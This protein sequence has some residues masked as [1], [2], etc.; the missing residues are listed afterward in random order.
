MVFALLCVNVLSAQDLWDRY[1]V[2]SSFHDG[3][4]TE[5]NPYQ[6]RTGAEL[7]YFVN[8]VN[9]GNDFKGKT[10]KL[11]NDI[12]LNNDNF[13]ISKPFAGSFDGGGH[14]LT[15][16][17]GVSSDNQPFTDVSGR[18]HHLGFVISMKNQY[19]GVYYGY[20]SVVG[21]LKESGILEDIHYTVNYSADIFYYQPALAY[22]N[23]G[24]IRN[25]YAGGSFHTYGGYSNTDGS[26]LVRDNYETGVIENCYAYVNR[27]I[28][29]V[30]YQA[31]PLA[32]TDKGTIIHNSRNIDELNKWVDEHPGHSSW[33]DT[34]TY[35]LVDFNPS[36]ECSI[37]FVDTLFSTFTPT[38][39]VGRGQ[40]IG[41]LPTPDADCTLAGWL[42]AG[43]LVKESDVVNA[44]WALFAKWEQRIKRQPTIK[45][46]SVG[47]DDIAHAT[48]QWFANSGETQY[49]ADV[50]LKCSSDDYY[51][52][53]I[54]ILAKAG[55]TLHFDYV[56]SSEKDYDIF[57]ASIDGQALVMASGERHGNITYV[58]PTDGTYKLIL[59]YSKDE[60]TSEGL[61]MANVT[62][63][64][65]CDVDDK[66]ECTDN[67]LPVSLVEKESNYFCK[68]CY[69]NTGIVLYTDTIHCVPGEVPEYV[70]Y[71][72]YGADLQ[73]WVGT[74]I[75]LSIEL[76]NEAEVKLCQFDLRLPDGVTVATKSNGKLD[77]K[78]TE[79]AENHS[80]SSQKLSNGDYRFVISSL[81]NDS[82]TG[83]N[84]TLMEITLNVLET[85]EAGEYTVKVLNTELSVPNGN[86]LM[87]VNPADTESKLT[88]HDYTPGD[89]NNDKSVSVT[90]V[91]CAI[92]YILEQIPSVFIFKAADMNSDNNVSVTDVGMIINVILS[93]G[94]ARSRGNDMNYFERK[95]NNE[96]AFLPYL[97]MQPT[98]DGY[99]LLL[100]NNE[101]YIGLQFDVELA[102]G[103][104][105]V[106][107]RLNGANKSD[108]LLTY[109]QLSNG[110]WRVVCYSPTNSTFISSQTSSWKNSLL[111]ICTTGEMVISNVRLTTI[112]F[113]EQCPAVRVK[114]VTDI[115]SVSKDVQM[116]IQGQT[117]SITSDRDVTLQIYSL[118]GRIYRNLHVRRGQ[119]SF[120]GLQ[121]GVYMINNQKVVLR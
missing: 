73:A 53:T 12:D 27:G 98:T 11:M 52:E 67:R 66:I 5:A 93:E 97:H 79:R 19:N 90:D 108:H 29:N 64:K 121:K 70:P 87:V 48:F 100:D 111:S 25:C 61:D 9:A 74:I 7:M 36:S 50:L 75:V 28:T 85:M 65:V 1:S 88:V 22:N 112:G 99:E 17:V 84:G 26:L 57:S 2:A 34:D 101:V 116:S 62:N 110:K 18:I 89:V 86:D 35:K 20:I 91:G 55:Q 13:S 78:L 113:D 59:R 49:F 46:L 37:E 80:V 38:L 21:T 106:D 96:N 24:T 105:I 69:S 15:M 120:D 81:D 60:S 6:I 10:V 14:I 41:E 102:E 117:L 42:R 115:A 103:A 51:A 54:D 119:N 45:N 83:N 109:R 23:Y 72:F 44:N 40:A 4:G 31:L 30:G 114:T 39:S 104:S 77:A 56:V 94:A 33:T 68:I 71:E 32:Y 76:A 63:I 8:M 107:V 58:F 92:N 95:M 43:K 3:E 47:V 118:D 16:M 82:F